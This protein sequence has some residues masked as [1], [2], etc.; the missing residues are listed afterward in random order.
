M[1]RKIKVTQGQRREIRELLAPFCLG[2]ETLKV[3]DW[4][5]GDEKAA[6]RL[7]ALMSDLKACPFCG[8]PVQL[9][10]DA[11]STGNA[12]RIHCGGCNVTMWANE[13]EM[14]DALARR[15]NTRPR[16]LTKKELDDEI[17]FV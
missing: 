6:V 10:H 12:L 9:E 16:P 17:P 11:F 15:W 3:L 7:D 5:L 8:H 2:T 1:T 4:W 14:P 13:G